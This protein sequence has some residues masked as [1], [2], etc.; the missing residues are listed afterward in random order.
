MLC[1]FGNH[2]LEAHILNHSRDVVVVDKLGVAEHHWVLAKE[3]ENLLVV[4][5]H[6]C[7]KLIGIF[8]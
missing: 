1:A 2:A 6:L 3:L 7:H 4:V 8:K 5:L